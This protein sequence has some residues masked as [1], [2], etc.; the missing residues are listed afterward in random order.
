MSTLRGISLKSLSH[1]FIFFKATIDGFWESWAEH[2]IKGET[3]RFLAFMNCEYYVIGRK[4]EVLWGEVS[5]SSELRN[6]R[7]GD[8][9][10]E[11]VDWHFSD[12]LS[13]LCHTVTKPIFIS[14]SPKQLLSFLTHFHNE[15]RKTKTPLTIEQPACPLDILLQSVFP[16]EFFLLAF[17]KTQT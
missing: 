1:H 3:P 4:I 9:T 6:L 13:A 12:T 14:W 15:F 2:R 5:E 16:A 17:D 11:I 8:L 7:S 10:C